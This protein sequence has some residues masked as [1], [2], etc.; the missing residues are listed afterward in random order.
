MKRR[1]V[2]RS[3]VCFVL[4]EDQP[5]LYDKAHHLTYAVLEVWRAGGGTVI[6]DPGDDDPGY[7]IKVDGVRR[8]E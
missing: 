6:V 5:V 2:Q 8:C 1:R 3:G 4:P 7:E